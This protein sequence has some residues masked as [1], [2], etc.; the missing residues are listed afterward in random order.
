MTPAERVR[1][2]LEM[3]VELEAISEAGITARHPEYSLEDAQWAA[4]RLRL[5][6]E[7]FRGAYPDAPVR[8]P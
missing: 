4:R 6:D 5:G 2:A 3:S 8:D 7:L 1:L